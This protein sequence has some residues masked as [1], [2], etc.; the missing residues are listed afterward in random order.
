MTKKEI[1][2]LQAENET[3]KAENEDLNYVL[4]T[5]NE[6]LLLDNEPSRLYERILVKPQL[7]ILLNKELTT[8]QVFSIAETLDTVQVSYNNEDRFAVLLHFHEVDPEKET[9]LI[10]LLQE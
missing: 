3:L 7:C 2:A 10:A 6:I 8:K 4:E 9:E 5:L 1:A